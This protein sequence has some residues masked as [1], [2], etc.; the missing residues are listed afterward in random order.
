[1]LLV[2][3]SEAVFIHFPAVDFS[4]SIGISRS[5]KFHELLSDF[6]PSERRIVHLIS[7]PE[8]KLSSIK[9]IVSIFIVFP[10][11]FIDVGSTIFIGH[12]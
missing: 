6:L 9:N 5:N 7:Q 10:E 12:F 1:M 3:G 2:M 4:V 11:Y 8:L